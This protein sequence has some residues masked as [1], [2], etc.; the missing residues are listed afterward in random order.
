MIRRRWLRVLAVVVVIIALGY[1]SAWCSAGDCERKQM[2]HLTRFPPRDR[3]YVIPESRAARQA[4]ASWKAVGS[5]IAV[6]D[7][8]RDGPHLIPWCSVEEALIW[9]PFLASVDYYWCKAPLVGSGG[10]LW[11]FCL[12]GLTFELGY[13]Y[14]RAS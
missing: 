2:E 6:Y 7:P 8:Q 10:N 1:L 3:Q 9:L 14:R 11:Y 13:S 12:F 4:W 5:T